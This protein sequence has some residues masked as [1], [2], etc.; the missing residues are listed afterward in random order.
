METM[1]YAGLCFCS[2]LPDL[3]SPEGKL[4]HAPLPPGWKC[5][6]PRYEKTTDDQLHTISSI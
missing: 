4:E 6:K 2:F 5:L 3:K 1:L